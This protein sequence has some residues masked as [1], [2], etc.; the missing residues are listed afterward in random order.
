MDICVHLSPSHVDSVQTSAAASRRLEF[1]ASTKT[2]TAMQENIFQLLA[3]V[4]DMAN[5]VPSRRVAGA[6][7]ELH[8]TKLEIID[9]QMK[10]AA[11]ESAQVYLRGIILDGKDIADEVSHVVCNLRRSESDYKYGTYSIQNNSL[12]REFFHVLAMGGLLRQAW[13]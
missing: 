12:A 6:L 9:T 11:L 8:R 4:N 10:L 5:A 13:P 7:K 2:I 3:Q 1:E